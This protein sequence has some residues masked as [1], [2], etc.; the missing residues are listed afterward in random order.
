MKRPAHDVPH[1][2]LFRGRRHGVHLMGDANMHWSMQWRKRRRLQLPW[3]LCAKARAQNFTSA[4]ISASDICGP[5]A[6]MERPSAPVGGRMPLLITRRHCRAPG[7]ELNFAAQAAR[8]RRCCDALRAPRREHFSAFAEFVRHG[9]APT[10]G[11]PTHAL[12]RLPRRRPHRSV[13]RRRAVPPHRRR[14]VKTSISF[15][16][17]RASTTVSSARPPCRASRANR[18]SG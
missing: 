14:M 9:R 5:K 2:L 11:P 3:R 6:G 17:C 18:P 15:C 8:L 4:I 1:K 10:D 7:P 16:L 12:T 13:S